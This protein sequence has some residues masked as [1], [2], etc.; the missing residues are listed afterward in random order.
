MEEKSENKNGQ[1]TEFC[2]ETSHPPTEQVYYQKQNVETNI[3]FFSEKGIPKGYLK[4]LQE[5]HAVNEM[6]KPYAIC[7]TE[8]NCTPP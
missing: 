6:N 7:I 2:L 1:R 5:L 8:S 4:M 3:N